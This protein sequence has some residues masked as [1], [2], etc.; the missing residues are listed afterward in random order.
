[1]NIEADPDALEHIAILSDGDA[2]KALSALE[3]AALT[4][5]KAAPEGALDASKSG[6]EEGGHKP[7][8]RRR[9]R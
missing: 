8:R 3:L 6:G 5:E 2:R 9:D 1:M 7:P 4:V